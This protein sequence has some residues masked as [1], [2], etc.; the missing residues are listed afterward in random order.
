MLSKLMK[1]FLILIRYKVPI[2]VVE[3]HTPEHRAYLK[4][5]YDS[6]D[7]LMS[8]PFVPCTSGVLWAQALERARIDEITAADPFNIHGVANY[9]VIEFNPG[10]HSP[11]LDGVFAAQKESTPA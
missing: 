5:L 8:G 4:T 6:Q 10:M 3:K 1:N 11:L 9:E 7:L 2:E